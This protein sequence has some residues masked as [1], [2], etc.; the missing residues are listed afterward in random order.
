[1][2]KSEIASKLRDAIAWYTD[3]TIEEHLTQVLNP[4]ADEAWENIEKCIKQLVEE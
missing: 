4:D 2:S 1:M 3:V